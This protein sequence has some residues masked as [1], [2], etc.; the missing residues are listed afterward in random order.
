MIFE[1]ISTELKK[2][3]FYLGH[4]ID[5]LKVINTAEFI[6]EDLTSEFKGLG[7][8]EIAY[9][10]A[11]GRKGAFGEVK[12]VNAQTIVQWFQQHKRSPERF[13]AKNAT[14]EAIEPRNEQTPEQKKEANYAALNRLIFNPIKSK[15]QDST[16]AA[17]FDFCID[18]KIISNS[19]EL[20]AMKV[21]I[22]QA[23]AKQLAD[24][25]SKKIASTREETRYN[26]AMNEIYLSGLVSKKDILSRFNTSFHLTAFNDIV[27]AVK[28]ELFD[29]YLGDITQFLNDR[30]KKE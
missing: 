5:Q 20:K 13:D 25:C 8:L 7:F 22:F 28:V 10:F 21:S 18:E 26:R 3:H 17:Y 14:Y 23:K 30:Y 4:A 1:I 16:K 9:V 27:R 2:L 6:F 19:E 24:I 11:Q 15:F 29:F 12:F